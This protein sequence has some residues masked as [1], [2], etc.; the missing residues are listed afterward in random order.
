MTLKI[1][2]ARLSAA[3]FGVRQAVEKVFPEADVSFEIASLLPLLLGLEL[4]R[5]MPRRP[6]AVQIEVMAA[7]FVQQL[8]AAADLVWD[9][10]ENNPFRS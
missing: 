8:V 1:T 5:V 2:P 6:P 9:D 3:H 10:D 4:A 7:R